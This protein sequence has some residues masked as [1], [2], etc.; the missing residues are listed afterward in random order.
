MS[1]Y[2]LNFL[3]LFIILFA[4]KSGTPSR[5]F[6]NIY[7]WSCSGNSYPFW[8]FLDFLKINSPKFSFVTSVVET[9][10]VPKE[11]F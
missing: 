11:K 10:L 3:C 9:I 8:H 1:K 7:I 2:F 4:H 6:S 5:G